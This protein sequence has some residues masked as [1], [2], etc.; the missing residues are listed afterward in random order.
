[1]EREDLTKKEE[2]IIGRNSAARFAAVVAA[3]VETSFLL[4]SNALTVFEVT[5]EISRTTF[6]SLSDLME[7]TNSNSRHSEASADNNTIGWWE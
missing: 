7:S 3:A 4:C 6:A 5:L 1:M 2:I